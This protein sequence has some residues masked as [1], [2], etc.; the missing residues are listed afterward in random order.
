MHR[1]WNRIFPTGNHRWTMGLRPASAVEFFA[2][3]ADWDAV[4]AERRRLLAD[5]LSTYVEMLPGA[6]RAVDEAGTLL[7]GLGLPISLGDVGSTPAAKLAAI[8][9]AVEPDLIWLEGDADR[10]H[11]VIAGAVC[12]PSSWALSEKLGKPMRLVHGPVPKLDEQLGR[13]ID[14]FLSKMEPGAAWTREN[15][16]LAGDGR[17]NHHPSQPRDSIIQRADEGRIWIR[18]EHQFLMK[19]P[20]SGEVLFAIHVDPVP[21]TEVINQA[22]IAER[23]A[24]LLE[25]MADEALQYKRLTHV[26]DDI[27]ALLRARSAGR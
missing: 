27:V 24:L 16:S 13:Q 11:R 7:A 1:E 26:R 12:F 19:L 9:R 14:A 20:R 22:G 2:R 5:D 17:L 15:W 18:L 25:T 8:G 10:G 23:L 21:L 3:T 4:L 6:E